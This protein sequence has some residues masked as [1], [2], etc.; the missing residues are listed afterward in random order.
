MALDN[1]SRRGI[2][3]VDKELF[4]QLFQEA[5]KEVFT[6]R[7][8]R[9]AFRSTGIYPY[10]PLKT[11]PNLSRMR[12]YLQQ[13]MISAMSSTATTSPPSAST[14]SPTPQTPPRNR[15]INLLP[16]T[17]P[18][19]AIGVKRHAEL[20]LQEFDSLN[21]Q[22]VELESGSRERVQQLAQSAH[23]SMTREAIQNE[24]NRQ[25]RLLDRKKG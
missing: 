9:S 14:A 2:T 13:L 15:T 8:C 11:F 10:N 24:T 23:M 22:G 7:L 16:P 25:L 20:H 12:S 3:G 19:N 6:N 17:T 5:R 18:H 21:C 4:M 1:A